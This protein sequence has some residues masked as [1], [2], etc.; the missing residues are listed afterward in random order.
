M[1]EV[2][3]PFLSGFVPVKLVGSPV[4]VFIN[5]ICPNHAAESHTITSTSVPSPYCSG[6]SVIISS[7]FVFFQALTKF[8][9]L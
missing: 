8:S 6:S 1:A 2:A 3:K 9:C 5:S 4:P 7:S